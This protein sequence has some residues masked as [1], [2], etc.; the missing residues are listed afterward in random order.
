MTEKKKFV[1]I[2]MFDPNF[3]FYWEDVELS[4]RIKYSKYDVYLNSK[5]KAKHNYQI[6]IFHI[7]IMPSLS[8]ISSKEEYRKG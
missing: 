7:A 2:G 5:A 8:T 4:Y 1:E 3:F 6:E